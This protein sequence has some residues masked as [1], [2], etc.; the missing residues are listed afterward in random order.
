MD[1]VNDIKK[2][3]DRLKTRYPQYEL[4]CSGDALTMTLLHGKVE[5]TR[6]ET[7]LYMNGKL[8]D[9][10]SSR[11]VENQDDLYELIELFLLQLREIGMKQ[12]NETYITA[13]AKAARQGTGGMLL[14]GL[15]VTGCLLALLSTRSLWWGLAAFVCPVGALLPLAL[16]HKQIFRKYWVCPKCGQPLPLDQKHRFPKMEYVSRCPHCGFALEKAPELAPIRGESDEPKKP[17]EPAK[18]LPA[19]GKRWPC[20]LT[21]GIMTGLVLLMVPALF[22]SE[23]PADPVGMWVALTLLAVLLVFGL[24]LLLCR[25]TEPEQWP[26]PVVV[27]RER[28][29]VAVCGWLA[30]IL[31]LVFMLIAVV[32]AGT[33][34]FD[35]GF[36]FLMALGGIPVTLLGVWMMLARR[37]RS[38]FVFGDRSILY[39]SSFGQERRFEPGQVASVQMTVNRSMHLLDRNGK[40]LAAVETNMQGACRFME[41]IE[42][43][44]LPTTLTTT[45]ER[46]TANAEQD[47]RITQWREEYRTPLHDHLKAIRAGRVL[48]ILLL[49]AGTVVPLLL[50]LFAGLKMSHAIYLTAASPLPMIVYYLAFAPVLTMGNRS[51]GATE[52]WNAMHI[53]FPAMSVVLMNMLLTAQV[54]HFWEEQ[55]LQIADNGPFLLLW[56]G[57]AGG[58]I[59]L[60]WKRTPKYTRRQDEFVLL[61]VSL[62]ALGFV[63]AYGASLGI[64][65]PVEHY[66]AVVT[67]RSGPTE[68]KE[69][70]DWK[71]TVVLDDG[72]DMELNV[73]ER[74]YKLE[75]AGVPIVVC[76]QENI[77]GIRMVRL[78]LAKGT[79]G[80][81]LPGTGETVP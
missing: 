60:F 51:A 1:G 26:Q 64:S 47:K 5:I 3:Y 44:D 24:A 58:L 21:G 75:E 66:P 37:N 35:G 39:I 17:L 9:H 30:W 23:E 55:I 48:V 8:Y 61:M 19:P 57:I 79:D 59:A 49:A 36:T 4:S 71:L 10:F 78:H 67:E 6:E 50:S 62:A 65:G 31:G 14:T 34:P 22:V 68:E 20:W 56:A 69:N 32:Y 7:R 77:L 27:V 15:L 74:L 13:K 80:S 63:L 81:A 76:Q 72:K 42:S 2:L 38:L 25:H 41:W 18:D 70:A 28:R 33:V 12:G 45:M 54:H 46:Q 73:G 43:V 40:K 29:A 16:I 52:E 53:K 11:K